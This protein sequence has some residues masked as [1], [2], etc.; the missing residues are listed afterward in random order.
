V[1]STA[2]PSCLADFSGQNLL[3][4][5]QTLLTFYVMGPKATEFGEIMQNNDH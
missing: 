1:K 2:R 3:M 4:A 5:N